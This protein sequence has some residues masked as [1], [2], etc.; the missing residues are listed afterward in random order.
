MDKSRSICAEFNITE[1]DYK[2]YS[3]LK[4]KYH[5]ELTLSELITWCL[6]WDAAR[7]KLQPYF[8]KKAG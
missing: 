5:N 2:R 1:A 6:E 3:L 7:V 8:N 4:Q